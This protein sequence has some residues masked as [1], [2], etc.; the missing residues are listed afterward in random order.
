VFKRLA[1]E[2]VFPHLIYRKK[3]LPENETTL[4]R[5]NIPKILLR[6]WLWAL[7]CSK[8]T[9]QTCTQLNLHWNQTKC[10]STVA[11][12]KWRISENLDNL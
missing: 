12:G 5:E 9:I 11:S 2:N 1:L 3:K 6:F 10:V 8:K 4:P 7:L